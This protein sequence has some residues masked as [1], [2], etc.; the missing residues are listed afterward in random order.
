M[1]QRIIRS[2]LFFLVLLFLLSSYYH[3]RMIS[4]QSDKLVGVTEP[5]TEPFSWPS[6]QTGKFQKV[7]DRWLG[8]QAGFH[9]FL[10]RL[11]NTIDYYLFRISSIPSVVTGKEGILFEPFYIVAYHGKDWIG[12]SAVSLQVDRLRRISGYLASYGIDFIFVLAPSKAR[13]CPEFIHGN[14]QSGSTN[15]SNYGEYLRQLNANPSL[16]VV[17][18]NRAFL[19]KKDTARYPLFPKYGIHWT[20]FICQTWV[21]DT[22]LRYISH[23]RGIQCPEFPLSGVRYSDS[24][25]VPDNDLFELLNL[26][27]GQSGEILPYPIFSLKQKTEFPI[28]ILTVGDSF[29]WNIYG[30]HPWRSLFSMNDFWFNNIARHPSA[31]YKNIPDTAVCQIRQDIMSHDVILL[32]VTEVNLGTLLHFPETM[33][34]WLELEGKEDALARDRWE[35][36][37]RFFERL[38]RHDTRWLRLVQQKASARGISADEMIHRDAMYMVE[39]EQL[40]K[41]NRSSKT[42][43]R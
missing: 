33:I 5:V 9:P 18:L 19:E 15:R 6:W 22:L 34:A 29:F 16:H 26:F 14:E 8:F 31:K 3:P 24:L 38:I 25:Q 1:L 37:I 4:V 11:N 42:G 2:I 20:N 30:N 43:N 17:D 39:Q 7:S 23:L 28:R 21:T 36:R 32:M 41:Q 35:G 27:H 12:V 40:R 10:V 13:F